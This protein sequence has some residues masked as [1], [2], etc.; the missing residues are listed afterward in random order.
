MRRQQ[1][2]LTMVWWWV[3]WACQRAVQLILLSD[4]IQLARVEEKRV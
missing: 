4:A 3:E 1:N 2:V